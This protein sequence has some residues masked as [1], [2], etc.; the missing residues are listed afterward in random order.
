MSAT[1]RNVVCLLPQIVSRDGV[2]VITSASRVR[3]A[4]FNSWSDRTL[5]VI[6]AV[7]KL[8]TFNRLGEG[9]DHWI[10][11]TVC[12]T[13]SALLLHVRHYV[14]HYLCVFQFSYT[15]VDSVCLKNDL[16]SA[17]F[18][19]NIFQCIRVIVLMN[20]KLLKI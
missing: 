2:V 13:T 19:Q 14:N 11:F 9:C 17:I 8:L 4:G 10:V 20:I 5:H 15:V 16:R 18:L 3:G 6:T 7:S 12:V 1:T